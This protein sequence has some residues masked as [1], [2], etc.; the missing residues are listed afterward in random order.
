MTSVPSPKVS[1]RLTF[2]LIWIVP[3]IAAAIGGW[4]IFGELRQRGPEITIEFADGAGVAANK[5]P[6]VYRGVSVGTVTAVESKTDLSG[7]IV[8][9]RLQRTGAALA[10]AGT[11]F[12]IVRAEIG[13]SGVSGL[14]TLLTGVRINV[15]PGNGP[16]ATTFKG[17]DGAPVPERPELGRAFNLE[18]DRLGAL[19]P[20]APVYYREVKVGAVETSRLADDS[21]SVSIRVR[22]F[23]PYVNLVRTNTKFWNAGGV[24][25]KVGLLGAEIKS[26]S[27]ESLL[28]GGVAFATPDT[29]QIAPVAADGS[30]FALN[31]EVDKEWLKWR[32]KIPINPQESTPESSA[33]EGV[34]P[35]VLKKP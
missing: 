24:S 17:S 34:V 29:G 3:V 32:P 35:S 23:T 2:P 4:M 18:S 26:T 21:S 9:V 6:L 31:G 12:W 5:T 22:I 28:A 16:P 15:Q 14:E 33:R 8:R 10:T 25:L 11:R 27:I 20:G 13:F 19:T 7:V 1:R 30:Q